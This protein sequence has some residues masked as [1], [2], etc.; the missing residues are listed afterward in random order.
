MIQNSNAA[1]QSR[2]TSRMSKGLNPDV[3]RPNPQ[4]IGKGRVI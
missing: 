3:P 4:P 2:K 1:E